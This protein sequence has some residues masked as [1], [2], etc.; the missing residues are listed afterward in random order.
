METRTKSD[1]NPQ[2]QA[3]PLVLFTSDL[4]VQTFPPE[5]TVE[6]D[7]EPQTVLGGQRV[8]GGRG[9]FYAENNATHTT[10][11]IV[12]T[13]ARTGP[14]ARFLQEARVPRTLA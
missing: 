12:E 3:A 5:W 1:H 13:H 4:A 11:T 7:A 8:H 9:V 6:A 14:R 10:V 2:N